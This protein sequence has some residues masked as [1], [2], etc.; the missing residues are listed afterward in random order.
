MWLRGRAGT[1]GQELQS[2]SFRLSPPG[3]TELGTVDHIWQT[4]SHVGFEGLAPSWLG[5]KLTGGL[6]CTLLC[7]AAV[8]EEVVRHL[9]F[10]L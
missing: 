5:R 3:S 8:K 7:G 4:R 10:S 1:R 9:D 6:T 2:L